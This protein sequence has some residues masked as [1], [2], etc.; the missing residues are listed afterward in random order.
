MLIAVFVMQILLSL[1]M[2]L[3]FAGVIL[4]AREEGRIRAEKALK[5]LT[6]EQIDAELKRRRKSVE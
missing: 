2:A 5:V 4:S 3:C 1:F 6:L